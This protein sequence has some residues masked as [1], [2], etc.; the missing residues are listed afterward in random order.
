MRAS[1]FL[2]V[3]PLLMGFAACGDDG[4]TGGGGAGASNTGGEGAGPI[5]C[6]GLEDC[7]ATASECLLRTCEGGFC[8]TTP[9]AAGTPAKTQALEDCKRIECDGA[10][11]SQAVPDDADLKNDNNPC[12]T[13]SCSM[14]ERVHDP[15]AVGTS[16]GETEVCDEGGNCVECLNATDCGT[17]T[18]CSS[19]VCEDGACGLDF[20]A[21]GTAVAAQT[22]GDCKVV[23][24]DG[25]GATT[26]ENADRDIF[27][28]SNPCTLDGCDAGTPTNV[29]QPG[30]PCGANGTC[31]DQGQCV[32]C[33]A[34]ADCPGTDDFCKTRTCIND[35]CGFDFTAPGTQLPAAD[36]TAGNCVTAVC[37]AMGVV[38]QQTTT[39]DIPVDGNDCTLDQCVGASPMNPN[40]SQGAPCMMGGSVCDGMGACVEC[41]TPA[42][43]PDPAGACIV[44]S[45]VGGMCGSQNAPNGSVCAAASCSGGVQQSAD[46]CQAGACIDG[47]SQPCTPYICGPSACTTSCASDPGCTNGF[48]CDTGLGECT[49]G[50]TCTDY[51]NIIEAN[52]TGSL[53]QYDGLAKCLETCSHMPDGTASDGSGNT[54]G[55]RTYHATASAGGGAATHCPHAGPTGAG[56]C[57]GTCES[58]CTIA[59][60]ACTGANQQF[61]TFNDCMTACGSYNMG[62]QYSASTTSGNSYACRMY[63]LTAA[64]VDPVG[65]C[66]HIVLASP[67]CM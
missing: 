5:P 52:C 41:N 60:G 22:S 23:V 21:A 17:P 19:P 44:A 24:C 50:P 37:G 18:E 45:C 36:Q 12:T 57:G 55:C 10:G 51:C 62:P 3:L 30:T 25:A 28:D 33:L 34:P 46:T 49:S 42:N 4:P 2:F 35:V 1:R 32:G 56:V 47:G 7:P 20:V 14:G 9:Q 16:C 13:D 6:D 29:A 11:S 31:N 40:A 59:Q 43:C 27:D 61:A 53:D 54:V 26:E 64:A 63:H 48:V 8:G 65:H 67:T 15:V 66:P 38:Q 39:S 58:F